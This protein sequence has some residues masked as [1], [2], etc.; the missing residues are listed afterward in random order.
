[1]W[2]PPHHHLWR[3]PKHTLPGDSSLPSS[4]SLGFGI[5]QHLL[6]N[7][8][9]LAFSV[10]LQAGKLSPAPWD[11]DYKNLP[12]LTEKKSRNIK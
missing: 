5:F 9:V 11:A 6:N 8:L 10:Q 4:L 3:Y 12:H 7:S 2:N 1:M